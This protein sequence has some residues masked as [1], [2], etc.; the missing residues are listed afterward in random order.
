MEALSSAFDWMLRRIANNYFVII[1]VISLVF[2]LLNIVAFGTN[3]P[4]N[5]F[6]SLSGVFAFF[7][8]GYGLIWPREMPYD[9]LPIF[10]YRA[11]GCFSSVCVALFL[12][13]HSHM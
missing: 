12:V 4:M 6:I 2:A 7:T 11:G 8:L 10:L 3:H 1:L 13:T 9:P 5:Y